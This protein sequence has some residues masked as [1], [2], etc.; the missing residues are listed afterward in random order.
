MRLL[1]TAAVGALVIFAGAASATQINTGGESGAYHASFCPRLEEQLRKSKFDY[2][3]TPSDGSLANIERVAQ[4]PTEI[5]FS[6]LDVYELARQGMGDSG[7][8]VLREDVARECLFI[9]TRNRE[10]TSFGEI[11]AL[12]PHIRF[13]LPPEASGSTGT[14][15]YLQTIDPDGLGRAVDISYAAST[16]EAIQEA[17]SGEDI[18]TLFVQFPDP[19]SERFKSI[20]AQEGNIVPVI[21]RAILR[22]EVDGRKIYYAEETEIAM[23]KWNRAAPTMV[24]ACTPLVIFSGAPDRI[25]DAN[26]RKDQEDLFRTVASLKP[27]DLQPKVGFFAKWWKKAKALSAKSVEKMVELSEQAKEAAGPMVEETM[28]RAKEMK[29]K[30][31]EA[32]QDLIDKA[33]KATEGSGN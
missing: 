12:A 29:D 5:G 1:T 15:R 30:A 25:D 23:P 24:T 16:D 31:S 13:V 11:Q 10:I 6:Q 3:C 8:K 2:T 26:Q 7:L 14:F 19:G 32:T 18:A 4:N 9:V 22:Q 33:K 20:A 28:K 27:A 21:D 17:L